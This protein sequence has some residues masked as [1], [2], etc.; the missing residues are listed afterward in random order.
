MA[1]S[2]LDF[3]LKRKNSSGEYDILHPTTTVE[4]IFRASDSKTL[5]NILS[6][7]ADT[8]TYGYAPLSQNG[9][10][11]TSNLPTEVLG[12]MK[13][14][15]VITANTDIDNLAL[16]PE[17]NFAKGTYW[18]IGTALTITSANGYSSV[19]TPGDEG[20][21]DIT[22]GIDLEPGDWLVLAS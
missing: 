12:G 5:T 2:N 18:Q 15:G 6:D 8:S 19:L 3:T 21:F 11:Y 1:S 17:Q 7:K 13:F 22:D 20:D 4:Q 10:I 16:I 9:K 14:E